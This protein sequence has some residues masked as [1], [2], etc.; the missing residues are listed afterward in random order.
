MNKLVIDLTPAKVGL[1]SVPGVNLN[2]SLAQ[3]NVNMVTCGGQAS[4]PI[5]YAIG[6]THADLDYIEVVSSIS[7]RS[8]GPATRQNLDEYIK[9]TEDGLKEFSGA[10]RTKAILNLNPAEPCVD[11]QTTIYARVKNPN[12]EKLSVKINALVEKIRE[13]VPGYEVILG[14]I[15]ENDRIVVMIRVRG[16][17]DYLPAYAGNLD[18]INCAAIA[19]AE[20]YARVICDKTP[21]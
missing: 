14:P 3:S 10:T 12:I 17:G 21:Q 1:M 11:M 15:I 6:Q 2:D 19:M 13:Y 4:I 16:L 20:E 9:T 18:I 8:A 7:S 5:A